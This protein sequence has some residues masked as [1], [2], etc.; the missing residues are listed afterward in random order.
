MHS[1]RENPSLKS[2]LSELKSS[3]KRKRVLLNW[4]VSTRPLR[5]LVGIMAHYSS[6]CRLSCVDKTSSFLFCSCP[7][8]S[9]NPNSSTTNPTP[10]SIPPQGRP[11]RD[12]YLSAGERGCHLLLVGTGVCAV[13]GACEE[14]ECGWGLELVDE[15]EPEVVLTLSLLLERSIL[16]LGGKTFYRFMTFMTF[17]TFHNLF[18][19]DADMELNK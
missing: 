5:H 6:V 14:V 12:L 16:G 1:I 11:R 18:W 13:E 15:E 19:T 7:P 8:S 3:G 2:A 9:P 10:S 4:V 17:T